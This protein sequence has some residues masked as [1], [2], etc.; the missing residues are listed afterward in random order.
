MKGSVVLVMLVFLV[1]CVCSFCIGVG[2]LEGVCCIV[3]SLVWILLKWCLLL[4]LLF[5]WLL[6]VL[7]SVEEVCWWFC[8]L[9]CVCLISF[10]KLWVLFGSLVFSCCVVWCVCLCLV[11]WWLCL[12]LVW[13]CLCFS[14][15]MCFLFCW[16]CCSFSLVRCLV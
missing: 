16:W 8:S 12:V 3:L 6:I 2:M 9:F 15:L 14:F 5:R 1:R 4:C 10:V 13:F 11:W 7:F